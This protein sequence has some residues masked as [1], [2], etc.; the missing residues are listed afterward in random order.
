MKY[1]GFIYKWTDSTNGKSY[2][3]SHA[4]SIND[5]YKGSGTLFK[6]A[7]KKRPEAFTKEILEYVYED[8][9]EKLLEV[10]QK[11]LD[12]IDW[13]NTY[14]LVLTARGGSI[15]GR[16]QSE[17][18]KERR[19]VAN[20]GKNH[21]K[22]SKKLMSERKKGKTY[23]E[24][25]GIKNA[26]IRKQKHSEKMKGKIPWNKGLKT[27]PQSEEHKQKNSESHKRKPWSS[28]RRTAQERKKNV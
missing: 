18:E 26:K 17:V 8:N 12:K 22:E 21:T 20:K 5:Y 6:R 9:R 2:I 4:G 19:S 10:E 23:E 13:S 25:Y 3:G 11:Y 28:A 7:Y 1:F 15:K 16:K 24:I 14:N 27:G